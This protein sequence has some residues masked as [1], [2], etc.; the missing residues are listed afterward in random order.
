MWYLAIVL[1][2]AVAGL[3]VYLLL[4]G[5]QGSQALRELRD[6][7]AHFASAATDEEKRE[8]AQEIRE[9]IRRH[10]LEGQAAHEAQQAVQEYLD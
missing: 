1:V 4:Q 6:A 8:A 2:L 9:V 5:A 3:I 10:H 7:Q